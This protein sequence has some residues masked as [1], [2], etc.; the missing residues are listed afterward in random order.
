[1]IVLKFI[2]FLIKCDN[3]RFKVIFILYK[4]LN[5]FDLL[6]LKMVYISLPLLI[7]HGA[8]IVSYET[9]IKSTNFTWMSVT[10][11]CMEVKSCM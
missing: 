7:M 9:D 11:A 2:I 8:K 5:V 4:I 6:Y 1:M 3:L 10:F